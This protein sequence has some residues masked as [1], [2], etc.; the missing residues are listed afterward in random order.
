MILAPRQRRQQQGCQDAND[1]Q[2]D[3]QFQHRHRTT[4]TKVVGRA[5]RHAEF[6]PKL[7]FQRLIQHLTKNLV[8]PQSRA[9]RNLWQNSSVPAELLPQVGVN[10]LDFHQ[11]L[12]LMR[13]SPIDFSMQVPAFG[14][15][16]QIDPL[17][18]LRAQTIR[19][20]HSL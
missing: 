17:V 5:R 13:E 14:F 19:K 15:R 7:H 3:E 20:Q 12:P 9:R 6:H 8:F 16:L 11:P 1:R 2:G 10:L 18:A 4:S